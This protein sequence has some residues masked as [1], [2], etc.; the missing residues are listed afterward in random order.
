VPE[1]GGRLASLEI[2][3]WQLLVPAGRDI[4]HWGNFAMAPWVGRLRG[5]AL[6]FRGSEH[7]FPLNAPPHA[8]HGLVTDRP[9]HED[10]PGMLSIDLPAIWPWRGRVTHRLLLGPDTLDFRL[11][12]TVDE[13]MPAA[14]GWHPWFSTWI[15]DPHGHRV[16]PIVL[17]ARPRHM[18]ANDEDGLPSGELVPPAPRPWDYCFRDLAMP[19]SVQWPGVLDLTIE[20]S[21]PDWVIYD[22]EPQGLCVEPWTAPP[23]A[24]NLPDPP[25]VTPDLPLVATMRW[26]WRRLG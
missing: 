15:T 16:G 4:F 9:W 20:S 26:R 2:D 8:L 17:D 23:N 21:C 14:L 6:R 13:P 25:V 11:E 3:G 12:L 5:G 22:Q 18:Y 19:P 10:G 24:L 7:R 1:E